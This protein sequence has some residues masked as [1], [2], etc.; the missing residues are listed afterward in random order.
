MQKS[1]LE[2]G[3]FF[4]LPKTKRGRIRLLG[5]VGW[6]ALSIVCPPAAVA[7]SS[8]LGHIVKMLGG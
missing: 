7:V 8:A 4:S 1:P 5:L 2:R 3:S 6:S